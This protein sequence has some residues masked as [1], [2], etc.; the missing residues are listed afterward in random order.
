MLL[1]SISQSI[2]LFG[3][4]RPTFS[5]LT[6]APWLNNRLTTCAE[7]SK[8]CTVRLVDRLKKTF[9]PENICMKNYQNVR[10]LDDI[11]PNNFVLFFFL[12]AIYWRSSWLVNTVILLLWRPFD[13][14]FW[15]I[16]VC[17]IC[18]FENKY[19]DDDDKRNLPR[20]LVSAWACHVPM[21]C[22]PQ[23]TKP[24][25]PVTPPPGW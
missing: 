18:Y 14:F 22:G 21:F 3:V 17:S 24:E 19:V 23:G 7:S 25:P 12:T 11:C 2:N 10:I 6:S 13:F 9:L 4:N 20:H 8:E 1:E 5:Q 15:I 16:S